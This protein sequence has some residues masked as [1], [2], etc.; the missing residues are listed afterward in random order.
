MSKEVTIK[1]GKT[2]YP[3]H[4]SIK[5]GKLITEKYGSIEGAFGGEKN[6]ET[7]DAML[8]FIE[9]LISQG[10]AKKKFLGEETPEP[11]EEDMLAM[12]FGLGDFQELS[13]KIFECVGEGKAREVLEK[14]KKEETKQKGD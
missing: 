3:M 1:I 13:E 8:F 9:T 12:L 14:V 10:I 4:F 5:A 7:F 11:I 2:E 6:A